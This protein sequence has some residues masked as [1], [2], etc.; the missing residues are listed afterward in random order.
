MT[1][2]IVSIDLDGPETE[3]RLFEAVD[4]FAASRCGTA[5]EFPESDDAPGIMIKTVPDGE[6]HRKTVIFQTR[7]E[8]EAFMYYWRRFQTVA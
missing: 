6:F 7:S 1:D 3:T 2:V 5:V 4:Q 8:A